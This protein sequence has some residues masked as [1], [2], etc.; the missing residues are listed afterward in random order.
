MDG[1]FRTAYVYVRNIYAGK[2][3][4]TD[5]GYEFKYDDGYIENKDASPV[6]FLE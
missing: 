1:D 3:S 2:L 5:N 6:S 4:E